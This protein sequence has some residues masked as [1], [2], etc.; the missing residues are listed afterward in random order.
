MR[1]T[2]T[3]PVSI[4]TVTSA[5]CTPDVVTEESPGCQLPSTEMGWVASSLHA[6][7]HDIPFDG[8]SRT[9]M[10]PPDATSDAASTPSAGPTFSL[11]A[12]SALTVAM[13]TA[14]LTAAAVVLP[15]DAPL[16]GYIVSPISGRI[17]LSGRPNGS[18]AIT[19]IIVR[20][21]VPRSWGP[22]RTTTRPSDEISQRACEGPGP[23]EGGRWRGAPPGAPGGP[24][25]E[26]GAR[27][28]GGPAPPPP[29][30]LTPTPTPVLLG[31]GVGPPAGGRWAQRTSSPPLRGYDRHIAFGASG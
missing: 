12:S 30:V 17:A 15:P 19:A 27:P 8:L 21:P 16:I 29:H 18:A 26:F 24:S 11:S 6:S 22:T 13:R 28:C 10:R 1:L 20:V 4:S 14:G 9:W 7:L 25:V 23:R 5:N 3:I 2:L 31:P